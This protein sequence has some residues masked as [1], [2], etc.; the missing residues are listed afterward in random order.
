MDTK[1]KCQNFP[2]EGRPEWDPL[3]C[4]QNLTRDDGPHPQKA[5][6][7]MQ[8]KCQN[9][10]KDGGPEEAANFMRWKCQNLPEDGGPDGAAKF[11]AVK[12]PK[13]A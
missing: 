9:L 6:N 13:F 5:A 10:P 7:F 4:G 3:H 1:V 12:M 2:K 8:W 11:Y